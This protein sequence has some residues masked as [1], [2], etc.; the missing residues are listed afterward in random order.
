LR[1]LV[2]DLGVS[3]RVKFIPA[4]ANDELCRQLPEFDI[5]AAHTEYWEISK[6]VLESLLTGLPVVINRRRGESVP[7]LTPEICMLVDNSTEEYGRAIDHLI[8]DHHARE[9]LG[10]AAFAHAQ[11]HWAPAITE[12]KFAAIYRKVADLRE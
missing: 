6:S 12:A 11:A 4:M 9:S 7:E 5:F 10:R 1:T 8:H 3:D 2:A